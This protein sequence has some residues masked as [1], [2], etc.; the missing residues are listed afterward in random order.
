[1]KP[2]IFGAKRLVENFVENIERSRNAS[3][4][5]AAAKNAGSAQV[6]PI[7]VLFSIVCEQRPA[8]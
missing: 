7:N 8:S 1:M 6:C 4:S 5:L 3:R 2:S